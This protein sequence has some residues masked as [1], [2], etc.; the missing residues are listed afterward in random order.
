[1]IAC[2]YC[3]RSIPE[4]TIIC[5]FCHKPQM[6]IKEQKLQAKRIWIVVIVAALNVGAVFLYM[7][8][9]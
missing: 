8:F 3:E 7:H 4:N 5:P 6:S 1:M 9:K 2:H